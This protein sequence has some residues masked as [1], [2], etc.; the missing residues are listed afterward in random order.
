MPDFATP[1]VVVLGI[2]LSVAGYLAGSISSAILVCR[3]MGLP[4]PRGIGSGNPGATNVLRTGSKPAA[5]LTLVGDLAKGIV[6]VVIA[7][8]VGLPD[9]AVAAV[10][11]ASFAGHLYPVFFGLKGGKGVATA[12][13]VLLAWSPLTGLAALIAWLAM[14]ATFRY[15]SLA[16]LTAA[17]LAPFSL[18]LLTGSWG[19]TTGGIVMTALLVW[20]HRGNIQ[21]LLAG[22]EPRIG[23]RAKGGEA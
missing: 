16:A 12:L 3:L 22:S 4:D 8:W 6:P 1:T 7:R 18:A 9:L 5:A 11:L 19:L 10:G 13:G 20:R 2:G 21:R 14:A 15:S 17:A 23:A